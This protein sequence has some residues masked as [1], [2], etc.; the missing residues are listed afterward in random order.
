MASHATKTV[1]QRTSRALAKC[2]RAGSMASC[3][4]LCGRLADS[5]APRSEP[6]VSTV[7]FLFFAVVF[8]WVMGALKTSFVLNF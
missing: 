6:Q 5:G 7:S 4:R 8:E 3:Q 2:P 1:G